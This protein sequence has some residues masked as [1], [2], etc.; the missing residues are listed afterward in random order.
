MAL[1]LADK[2]TDL[3]MEEEGSTSVGGGSMSREAVAALISLGYSFTDADQAVR[4]AIEE[5]DV[6]SVDQLI[7]NAL[8][9]RGS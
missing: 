1:E 8:Q 9:Q 5:T 3:A 6:D 7:R 4:L 2:V